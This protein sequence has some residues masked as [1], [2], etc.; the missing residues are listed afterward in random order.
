MKSA[1]DI[2]IINIEHYKYPGFNAVKNITAIL[3]K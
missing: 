3:E 1:V 2:N